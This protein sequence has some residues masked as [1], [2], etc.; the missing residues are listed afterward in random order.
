MTHKS[1]LPT[2]S[3]RPRNATG[4]SSCVLRDARS[5]AGAEVRM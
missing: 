3:N 2:M 1:C 4:C 5:L